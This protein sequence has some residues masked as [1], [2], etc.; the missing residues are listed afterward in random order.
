MTIARN[1]VVT[2]G[3]G[4][5]ATALLAPGLSSAQQSAG[6]VIAGLAA[7]DGGGN[8]SV[9]CGGNGNALTTALNS[10]LPGA[11]FDDESVGVSSRRA[12]FRYCDSLTGTG[13]N[14][15]TG[16]AGALT[17]EQ[18][19]S[20]A[21]A[22]AP[23]EIF[24]TMDN[25]RA[26]AGVQTANVAR[27]LSLVRLTRRGQREANEMLARRIQAGEGATALGV[28]EFDQRDDD[29]KLQSLLLGLQ[30]G[31]SAGDEAGRGFS[32]F[33]N[34]RVNI[35]KGE[36]S[37]NERGSEGIGGGFT[38]GAD[39][40]LGDDLFAGVA[41]G[42]TRMGT[43]YDGSA[44]ESDL[45][46][47]SI[48]AYGGYFPNDALYVDTSLSVSYLGVDTTNEIRISDGGA[49]LSDLEGD[50]DGVNFGF[51]LGTGYAFQIE[52]VEGLSIEPYARLSVLYTEI[53]GFKLKGGDGSIDLAIQTQKTTSVT[54]TFGFRSEY[55]I[56]TK[57]GILTPYFRAAYV[58]EFNDENDDIDA[59]FRIIPGSAFKLRAQ[60][61]DSHYG[62][63]GLGVAATLSQGLAQYV[64][65][66]VI[67]GHDNVTVHQITAGLRLEF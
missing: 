47:V 25:A 53:D 35:V 17:N 58:H 50:T 39:K 10:A 66:D 6:E 32:V 49:N 62:N 64:D 24:A 31:I 63:F 61:T 43:D 21:T 56:S 44:S 67:G 19:L 4:L 20:Q 5:A 12:L 13:A 57:H 60:A 41:F 26:A 3:A 59:A 34:G 37:R 15:W 8:A 16:D 52:Q 46:A 9:G 23:E 14:G 2:F 22:L 29:E 28:G 42:Y 48:T 18:A 11:D 65:Y 54:G 55:P 40:P 30:E 27:R 38:I 51:D 7:V 33:L 36:E 45:D 1:F